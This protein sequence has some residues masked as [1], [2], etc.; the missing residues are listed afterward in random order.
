MGVKFAF[1]LHNKLV[2]LM[3]IDVGKER[4][5]NAALRS[6][7]VCLMVLP[8]LQISCF[9]KFVNQLHHT[10][11]FDFTVNQTDKNIVVDVIEATFDIALNK[12]PHTIELSF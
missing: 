8:V 11:I 3:Q 10:G 6:S 4:G 5:N 1:Q 7:A 12:P 2:Q 9:Q